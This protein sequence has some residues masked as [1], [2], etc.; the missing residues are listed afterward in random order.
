MMFTAIQFFALVAVLP[1]V[2][3]HAGTHQALVFFTSEV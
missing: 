3:G 1:R 2:S